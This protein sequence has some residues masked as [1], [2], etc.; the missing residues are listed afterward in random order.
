MPWLEPSHTK[1]AIVR[2]VRIELLEVQILDLDKPKALQMEGNKEKRWLKYTNHL[3]FLVAW[4]VTFI[5][6]NVKKIL[7]SF[8]FYF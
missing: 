8:L 5:V 4:N 1:D 6:I 7:K 2:R 3:Y